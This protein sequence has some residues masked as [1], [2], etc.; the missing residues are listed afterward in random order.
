MKPSWLWFLPLMSM[1]TLL[2][3]ELSYTTQHT[4]PT[5]NNHMIMFQVSILTRAGLAGSLVG[6]CFNTN[7]L[8]SI[9]MTF[10]AQK[11]PSNSVQSSDHWQPQMHADVQI[12]Y[13][14]L[15]WNNSALQ[16]AC[17]CWA[18]TRRATT[19]HWPLR[20]KF[21][22]RICAQSVICSRTVHYTNL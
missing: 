1:I 13:V 10:S 17:S 5:Y 2:K 11:W 18:S 22:N 12:S 19:N 6:K 21:C 16:L 15:T 14:Y 4:Q 8:E 3:Q 7:L 20:N 9:K